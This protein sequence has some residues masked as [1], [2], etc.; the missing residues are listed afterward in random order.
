M[1]GLEDVRNLVEKNPISVLLIEDNAIY[2]EGL[3]YLLSNSNI[4]VMPASSG[5][6]AMVIL[7][8]VLPDII[9]LDI[10]LGDK[11]S[12]FD[13]LTI[14]KQNVKYRHIPVI[15]ISALSHVDKIQEG[16]K[17][18]ANDYL[19]KP[20]RTEELILKIINLVMITKKNNDFSAN[21]NIMDQITEMDIE[22]KL[23]LD[24]VTIVTNIVNTG[25]DTT[26]LKIVNQ[27]N[28]NYT[29]LDA[30][31]KKY[32]HKTPVNYILMKRLQRA[33]LMVRNSNISINNI[34][35]SAGFKSTSYFCTAY[36]KHF[37]KTPLETR[38]GR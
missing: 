18:G 1:S 19:T 21:E 10:M 34:A 36:K 12:G 7:S 27:L 2:A 26:V 3:S 6:Q 5:E 35:Y 38:T 28:T 33:D 30:V 13:F 24:F 11:M 20:L 37:G 8:G 9:V 23:S 4:T 31:V 32:L 14:L 16:L 25:E 22:Y 17:L 29:R 15:L